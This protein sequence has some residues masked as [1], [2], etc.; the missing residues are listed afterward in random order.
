[1]FKKLDPAALTA[2]DLFINPR[3][4]GARKALREKM[5]GL[6]IGDGF[7]VPFNLYKYVSARARVSLV[8]KEFFPDRQYKTK[9]LDDGTAVF[10]VR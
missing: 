4:S 6:N 7:V 8:N 1:M 9:L 5:E 3:V 10:R 2:K